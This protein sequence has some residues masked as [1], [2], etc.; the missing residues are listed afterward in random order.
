MPYDI[1]RTGQD[2]GYVTN[3][4]TGR[5]F[6][7]SP[8]PIVNAEKQ[9]RLLRAQKNFRGRGIKPDDEKPSTKE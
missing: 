7:R 6:S 1:V 3:T 8:I 4:K 5:V 2:K 9:I